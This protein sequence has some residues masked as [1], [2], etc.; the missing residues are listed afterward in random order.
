MMA[1]RR[2]FTSHGQSSRAKARVAARAAAR[3]QS[4][5][6]VR[7]VIRLRSRRRTAA[8]VR[9]TSAVARTSVL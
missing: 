5:M 1:A 3:A 2:K 9:S 4:P 8:L 6:A 7:D